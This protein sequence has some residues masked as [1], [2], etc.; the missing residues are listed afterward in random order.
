MVL[1]GDRGFFGDMRATLTGEGVEEGFA[2]VVAFPAGSMISTSLSEDLEMGLK[3]V[4][5]SWLGLFRLVCT[6]P[7]KDFVFLCSF[8]SFPGLGLPGVENK[9][10]P[11]PEELMTSLS[12]SLFI[13]VQFFS[14]EGVAVS[15]TIG[16][17]GLL[18]GRF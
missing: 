3:N 8:P 2:L 5:I 18:A 6:L 12:P 9:G 17:S 16:S 14:G 13:K 15:R 11:S 10:L 7:G 4:E 1:K